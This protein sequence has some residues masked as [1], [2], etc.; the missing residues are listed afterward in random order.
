MARDLEL[1]LAE[2]RERRVAMPLG[3]LVQQLWTLARS[4]AASDADHTEMVRLYEGWAGVKVA[5]GAPAD[6]PL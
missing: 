2:A 1:C 6:G 5:S 3:G 4:Q